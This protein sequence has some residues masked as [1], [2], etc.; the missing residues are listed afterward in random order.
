[1]RLANPM[2][3][4][5]SVLRTTLLGSLLD[6]VRHNAARGSSDLIVFEQGAVYAAFEGRELPDE[7]RSLGALLHGRLTAPSWRTGE[8][9]LADVFAAK[10]LLEAVFEALRLEW[11]VEQD[12]EPFLHPGRAG[13]VWIDHEPV[14]WVGELHPL[15]ARA[16]DLEGAAGFEVDLDRVVAHAA[17]VPRY[18][19]LTS[20]PPVRRDLALVVGRDVPAAQVT[21]AVESAGAP[22]LR[23]LSVF[24]VYEGEQVGADRKSI[25]LHLEFQAEDRTLTDDEVEQVMGRILDAARQQAG[26]EQRG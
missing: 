17:V 4:D 5:H 18:Q 11:R 6:V 25:A 8:A 13:R 21:A 22:L 14:G 20:F 15:V 2:S 10:G 9:P 23:S 24:D 16:W 3:E 12:T 1:V 19:D 26:A 7:H